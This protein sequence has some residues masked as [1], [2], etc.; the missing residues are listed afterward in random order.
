VLW[1]LLKNA[2][3]FT[4]A[5]GRIVV[6]SSNPHAGIFRVEVCDSGRG[7]EPD[8]LERIFGAFEQGQPQVL[9][10]FGGLGLG[11][12]IAKTFVERHGGTIRA[13]S[14]GPGKGTQI[15]IELPLSDT[16]VFAPALLDE[17]PTAASAKRTVRVLLVDD[18]A[19]T[20][21]TLTRLLTRRGHTVTAV[22][23]AAAAREE[24]AR[25]EFDV[26]I[27]DVGLPDASGL[28]L[29]ADLRHIRHTPAIALSGYGMDA[30]LLSSKAAGFQEHLTKPIDFERLAR[31]VQQVIGQ[32]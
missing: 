20:L 17:A 31:T 9:A 19:D 1:N 2:I 7:I 15:I 32:A 8:A 24:F 23:T 13:A 27:S 14:A 16:P 11:L 10:R 29:I 5:G 21:T 4:P 12:A 18:H 22:A 6:L 26:I 25:A 30:D 3:K 28:E